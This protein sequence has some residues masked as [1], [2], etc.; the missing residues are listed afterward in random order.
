VVKNILLRYLPSP[1]LRAARAYHYHR[2]LARVSVTSEVDLLGCRNLIHAG[3]TVVDI[4]ANFGMY[5][6]FLSEFVGPTG[7]VLSLEPVPET[8]SYLTN[9]VR[10]LHLQNVRCLNVAVSEFDGE[11][12]MTIP[13]YATGG[14]NLFQARISTTGAIAVKTV[15]LDTLLSGLNPSF[16][17]C[18]VEGHELAC[19]RGAMEVIRLLRP[20]WLIEV[21]SP[22]T[23]DIMYSL[24]YAAYRF[25]GQAFCSYCG[26][27]EVSNY[28]FLPN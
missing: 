18:D 12:R 19:I 2:E 10:A 22:D 13:Q 27:Q 6:R 28:F 25:D 16:I 14:T 26:K 20:V 15:R 3:Q 9:N 21:W 1:L 11:A 24:G 23:F 7:T 8:F 4:G 17:K 5:T